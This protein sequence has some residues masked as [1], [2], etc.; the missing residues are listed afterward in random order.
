MS[1]NVT[2]GPK[3]CP[4]CGQENPPTAA[5]CASCLTPLDRAVQTT[6]AS[7][8]AD[9]RY[10]G[11]LHSRQPPPVSRSGCFNAFI[12]VGVVFFTIISAGLTFFLTCL[13]TAYVDYQ[14]GVRGDLSNWLPVLVA[15]VPAV[16][17][18]AL[19]IFAFRR[20][21]RR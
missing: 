19:I 16:A 17:V 1:T 21:R 11:P 12:L 7:A 4:S 3:I 6:P 9:N 20:W 10:A 8:A 13:G 15:G 14:A 18:A 5:R 2:R